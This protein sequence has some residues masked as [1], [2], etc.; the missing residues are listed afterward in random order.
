[1]VLGAALLVA[2]Q[3]ARA[4]DHL[5]RA[6]QADPGQPSTEYALGQ[7]LLGVGKSA[8]AIPHLRKGFEAGIEIPSGGSDYAVALGAAGARAGGVAA[9]RRITPGGRGGAESWLRIGRL[10]MSA[11]AP[12]LAEP[13][14]R[15]A[16]E[17][18]PGLAAAQQQLGVDLLVLHRL[19]E[20]AS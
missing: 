16:V 11:K 20:A 3:P 14:F 19:D 5:R 7:A 6:N 12:D 1:Y 13:Y 18:E 2:N 10:A 4:L 17:M 8:E 9:T 15:H